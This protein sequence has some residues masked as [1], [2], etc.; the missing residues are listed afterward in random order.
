MH[1]DT[2]WIL[3]GIITVAAAMGGWI[4]LAQARTD[5]RQDT[6]IEQVMVESRADDN[7]QDG[8]IERVSQQQTE[9]AAALREVATTLRMIDE[10]GT[11]HSAQ[12]NR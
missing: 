2:K 7:R 4:I 8:M 11:K 5:A 10:R 6:H 3:G 12:A 9:T 1:P